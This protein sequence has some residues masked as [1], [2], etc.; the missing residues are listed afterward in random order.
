MRYAHDISCTSAKKYS[1][2]E[3]SLHNNKQ[4]ILEVPQFLAL[5]NVLTVTKDVMKFTISIYCMQIPFLCDEKIA[6]F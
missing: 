3:I 1:S 5:K 4:N 6:K 2:V